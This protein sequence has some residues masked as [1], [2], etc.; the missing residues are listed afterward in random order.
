[1]KSG[2][3]RCV[4]SI[5]GKNVDYIVEFLHRK[6]VSVYFFDKTSSSSAKI[7]IDFKQ[8]NKL[9]AICNNMSYNITKVYYKG[10]LS[11]F[12]TAIDNIGFVLGA[13]LFTII[14]VFMQDFI[15]SVE[16]VGTGSCFA[17]QTIEVAKEAGAEPFNRF[18]SLNFDAISN[19]ILKQNKMLS[20][21]SLKQTGNRLVIEAQLN[22]SYMNTLTN[23]GEDVLSECDGVIEEIV[24][25]RGTKLKNVG[26]SVTKGEVLVKALIT[27][28]NGIEYPS[29]VIARVSVIESKTF[30]FKVKNIDE[31]AIILAKKTAEFNS[32][33]EV[34]KSEAVIKDGAILVT[35]NIR[36][37]LYGG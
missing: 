34:V 35:V 22:N 31:N 17:S 37:V 1:M 29:Y 30:N 23:S 2:L 5:I 19:A 18:S 8:R 15:F 20:F 24:V 13:I 16:V 14:C 36:H 3:L 7:C 12:K 6:G 11:P 4:Y 10:L 32:G 9:F 26:D 28:A 21:V 25:L 33:G 27:D